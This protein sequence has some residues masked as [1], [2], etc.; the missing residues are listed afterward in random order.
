MRDPLGYYRNNT[1]NAATL[2]EAAVKHD[3]RH[4]IFSSTAAVYGDPDKH[5]DRR[6]CA[7][8]TDVAIRHVETDDRIYAARRGGATTCGM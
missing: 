6:G 5:S 8:E 1:A 3:V 2:L 7:D 4:F